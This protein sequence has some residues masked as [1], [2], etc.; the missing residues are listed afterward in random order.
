MK[1]G[2]QAWIAAYE[3]RVGVE[4]LTGKCGPA[5]QEMNIAFPELRVVRGA[6]TL[7]RC[8]C[9]WS[10][11]WCETEEGVVVD[12]TAKQFDKPMCFKPR[13][14]NNPACDGSEGC[15]YDGGG[16]LMERSSRVG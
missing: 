10:H 2:Y 13:R 16:Y 14:Y 1:P 8:E 9:V 11:V 5:A 3:T 12:P 6:V 15:Q 4:N 7:S